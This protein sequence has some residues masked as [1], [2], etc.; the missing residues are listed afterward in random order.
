[1]LHMLFAYSLP[2]HT[3]PLW[4]KVVQCALQIFGHF[5]VMYWL[6]GALPKKNHSVTCLQY[7]K[8]S[9]LK[10]FCFV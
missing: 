4:W 7:V 5:C 3:K 6:K 9:I 2:K 1:M 8:Y 10:F